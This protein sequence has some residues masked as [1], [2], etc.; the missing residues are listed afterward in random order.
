MARTTSRFD[1]LMFDL[2]VVAFGRS[3]RF[4]VA[5]DGGFAGVG[6]CGPPLDTKRP[7][8]RRTFGRESSGGRI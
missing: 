2:R 5:A 6:R 1:I 8:V 7:K 4:A 3:S